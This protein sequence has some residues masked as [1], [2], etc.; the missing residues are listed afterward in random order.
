MCLYH[1]NAVVFIWCYNYFLN[2]TSFYL[3]LLLPLVAAY[4]LYTVSEGW[5]VG[6]QK[7]TSEDTAHNADF[8]AYMSVSDTLD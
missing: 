4:H 1:L 6:Q 8:P 2:P 7:T 5:A 3:V